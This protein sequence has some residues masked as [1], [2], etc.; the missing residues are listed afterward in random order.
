[1]TLMSDP[2]E[3]NLKITFNNNDNIILIN[4]DTMEK[5]ALTTEK[6]NIQLNDVRKESRN[7]FYE[8]KEKNEKVFPLKWETRP[9]KMLQK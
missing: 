1:M 9:L 7:R 8:S 3:Q 5:F 6:I 2:D 4:D